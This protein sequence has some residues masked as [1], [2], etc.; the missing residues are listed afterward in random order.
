MFKRVMWNAPEANIRHNE[1]R[2]L[3]LKFMGNGV[4]YLRV[5]NIPMSYSSHR[6]EK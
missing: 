1:S 3:V 4:C 2:L 5:T 6:M